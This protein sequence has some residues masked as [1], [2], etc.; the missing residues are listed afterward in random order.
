MQ[1]ASCAGWPTSF[2]NSLGSTLPQKAGRRLS[3]PPGITTQR[4]RSMGRTLL[5]LGNGCMRSM[6]LIDCSQVE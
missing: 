3:G 5:R 2:S 4:C 6:P 1:T